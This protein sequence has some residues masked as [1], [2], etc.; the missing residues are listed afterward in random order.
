M[1]YI[2][3]T[4]FYERKLPLYYKYEWVPTEVYIVW[5][6]QLLWTSKRSALTNMQ[7]FD[8]VQNYL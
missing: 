1:F 3:A 7:R 4:N 8:Y 5:T 6:L 2:F